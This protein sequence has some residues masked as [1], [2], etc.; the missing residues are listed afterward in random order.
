MKSLIRIA[1]GALMLAGLLS[2][3]TMPSNTK[4]VFAG[5]NPAPVCYPGDPGCV[6]PIP[7]NR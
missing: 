7:P 4:P 6:P 5:G 1:I 3:A 2:A